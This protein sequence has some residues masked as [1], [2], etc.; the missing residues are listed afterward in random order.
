MKPELEKQLY[1]KYPSLFIDK[2]KSIT[3]SCMGWGCEHDDGWFD[4]LNNLCHRIIQH[5]RNLKYA[6]DYHWKEYGEPTRE[7]YY[8][9]PVKFT[10]IKEK[11]GGLTI[12]HDG[13]DDYIS[14]LIDMAES[15]SFTVCEVC[16][17]KGE[18]NKEGWIKT[19]C[20]KHRL[21]SDSDE[22]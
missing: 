4:I 2:D 14:G 10:Q 8:Y 18:P 9:K 16:G 15:I 12:Y 5:E 21:T 6:N 19:T 7:Y 11:F 22:V 13:G 3:E 20:D 1:D 17:D